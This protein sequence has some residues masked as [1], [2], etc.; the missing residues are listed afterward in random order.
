MDEAARHYVVV[1]QF[2][3]DAEA[4]RAAF[5]RRLADRTDP[6]DPARFAW[7][8]WHVPGQFSQHR[9]PAR[10]FFPADLFARFEERLLSWAT[11]SLGL[12]RLGGPPWLSYLVDGGFQALHRD[13]P[14]GDFAFSFGLTKPTTRRFSGGETFLARPELLDYW[15][16]GAF[17]SGAADTPLFDE[18]PSRFNRLVAFDSRVPHGVVRVEGPRHPREGRVAVQGW[19]E[20]AGPRVLEGDLEPPDVARRVDRALDGAARAALLGF[21]G[22]FSMHLEVTKAGAVRGVRPLVN[23][24]VAVS[25]TDRTAAD[26]EERLVSVVGAMDLPATARAS[27]VVVPLVVRAG[28]REVGLG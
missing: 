8:Y 22:L 1:D 23:T 14:N 11:A 10:T 15:K 5:D 26:L 18:I 4:L 9:T 16:G 24:L 7:E 3:P 20:S 2:S 19:L 28:G 25:P 17:R 13:S 21:E 12:S 27:R 6:F